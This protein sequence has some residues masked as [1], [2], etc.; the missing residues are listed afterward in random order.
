M[1]LFKEPRH[2]NLQPVR[3]N[4]ITLTLRR[5]QLVIVLLLFWMLALVLPGIHFTPGN[6]TAIQAGLRGTHPSLEILS[7]VFSALALIAL[8]GLLLLAFRKLIARK[9][10]R[11][12]EH[13]MYREPIPTPW[14]IYVIVIFILAAAGGLVWWAWE[15][16]NMTERTGTP[17]Y[18]QA[19]ER[20]RE[21][22]SLSAAP[23][24]ALPMREH[25]SAEWVVI[26]LAFFFAIGLGVVLWRWLRRQ[27]GRETLEVPEVGQAVAQAVWELESG[28]ELSDIVLGCYREMC[29]ILGQK[30]ALRREMTAREFVRH[31][32]QVGVRGE[33]IASLTTLFE[34]VRY[35]RLAAGPEERT[36]TIALLKA[37]ETR[38]GKGHDEA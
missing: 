33:E 11:D 29:R 9:K 3:R 23:P 19:P 38:Y 36:E 4:S 28:G 1:G 31:L 13:Q 14:P 30:A 20:D 2:W 16:P 27:S 21:K 18:W 26:P 22:E 17:V 37:I 34:R 15:P 5:V 12:P 7:G 35:G 10:K 25:R 24:S 8:A 6:W 32:D